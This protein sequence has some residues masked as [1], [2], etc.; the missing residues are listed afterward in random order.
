MSTLAKT[1]FVLSLSIAL[2]AIAPEASPQ[3]SQSTINVQ[4]DLRFRFGGSVNGATAMTFAFYSSAT[5]ETAL[6]REAQSVSVDAGHYYASIGSLT[7]GG[8]PASALVNAR[9]YLGIT[10]GTD[11]EMAPRIQLA[12]S[13]F[14]INAMQVNSATGVQD[15]G[16]GTDAD[17]INIGTGGGADTI[18]M[19]SDEAGILT[20]DTENLELNTPE[21]AGLEVTGD[22]TVT[23][24]LSVSGSTAIGGNL[25]GA[26]AATFAGAG[27]F[28]SLTS[29]ET[30][31]LA[32][33]GGAT[34]TGGTLTV[35]TGATLSTGGLTLGGT[36]ASA[37]GTLRRDG[38][39]TA[40]NGAIVLDAISSGGAT[41]VAVTNSNAANVANLSVEGSVSA[42]TTLTVTGASTSIGGL[43]YAWPAAQGA[44]STVLTNDGAGGLSWIAI[45]GVG[46]DSLNFIE[47]AD[48][49]SLDAATDIALGGLTLSTSGP[50]SVTFAHTTSFTVAAPTALATSGGATT[51]GGTLAVAGNTGLDGDITLGN[52]AGD[53]VTVTGT[54]RGVSPLA[55]EGMTVDGTNLTTF[56][57]TDPTG[58]NT[59]TFKDG[60][61]TVAFLSDIT[62]GTSAA[63]FTTLTNTTAAGSAINAA[64]VGAGTPGTGAFT[65]LNALAGVTLSSTLSV[66]SLTTLS[67]GATLGAGSALTVGSTTIDQTTGNLAVGGALDVTGNAAF[68]GPVTIGDST[69]DTLTVTAALLGGAPLVFEGATAD[70]VNRTAFAIADPTAV[71]TL[72]IPNASGTLALT[73]DITAGTLDGSFNTLTVSGSTSLATGPVASAVQVG[74]LDATDQIAI[75]GNPASV[76]SGE[77]AIAGLG[78]TAPR[79]VSIGFSA[80]TPNGQADTIGIGG[81]TGDGDTVTLSGI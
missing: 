42:G 6:F 54:I 36:A 7:P 73:S 47:L 68:D 78:T 52:A 18:A 48:G 26:G 4:G 5:G 28:G 30:A 22:S 64:S 32:T 43:T 76:M 2:A 66:S 29:A 38:A 53:A 44:L 56:A 12:S 39:G 24:G 16:T 63:T 1:T 41:T 59:I 79:T 77:I 17:T 13:A 8:I 19:G 9:V 60:S 15:I 70:G 20:I 14:A 11:A 75:G 21:G 31:S 80:I 35:A 25:S 51:V 72:T 55:F 46:P 34:S 37:D 69:A 49:M 50:G 61:G 57:I 81:G 10:V 62:G 3:D 27:S 65:T 71:N 74:S 67:G 33:G 58:A 45:P 23:G 40:S